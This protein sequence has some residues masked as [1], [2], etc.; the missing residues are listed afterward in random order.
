[1][2]KKNTDDLNNNGI[3]G[4][5][6]SNNSSDSSSD[7]SSS[8]NKSSNKSSNN[9]QK[10]NTVAKS[11]PASEVISLLNDSKIEVNISQSID[12]S[13]SINISKT[14]L[15]ELNKL[16]KEIIPKS[17]FEKIDFNNDTNTKNGGA[18]DED[19]RRVFLPRNITA[20]FSA[21]RDYNIYDDNITRDFFTH[22]WNYMSGN[23][24]NLPLPRHNR[25][26]LDHTRQINQILSVRFRRRN[27]RTRRGIDSYTFS[28]IINISDILHW[29][30]FFEITQ[31]FTSWRFPRIHLTMSP[32]S[33]NDNYPHDIQHIYFPFTDSIREAVVQGNLNGSLYV[34]ARLM[35]GGAYNILTQ[36]RGYLGNTYSQNFYDLHAELSN[37]E[38]TY[39]IHNV[40]IISTLHNEFIGALQLPPEVIRML[41]PLRI[42][43]DT[44]GR[45][46]QERETRA[47]GG[48]KY[49]NIN[50]NNECL[51]KINNI[52]ENIKL[53]KK[54]KEKNHNKI[55]KQNKLLENLKAKIKKEKE[56]EKM[57]SKKLRNKL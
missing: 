24:Y 57:I 4:D 12:I 46:A 44:L 40:Y 29:T 7:S 2:A 47:G 31:D 9:R 8:S 53:L 41:E 3:N 30:I 19:E 48:K 6:I 26:N 18:G 37:A 13:Q 5:S 32:W 17:P 1:M 45:Q 36:G 14:E 20:A 35:L 23:P 39:P 15:D 43:I 38:R 28:M 25:D 52:K 50:K 42:A 49:K 33:D 55:E 51:I 56:R 11:Q 27:T 54:N 16:K 22:L 10:K 34:L 21:N